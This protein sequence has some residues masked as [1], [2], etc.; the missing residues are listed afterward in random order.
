MTSPQVLANKVAA[1]TGAL[2]GIG[3]AIAIGYLEHGAKV[4]VNYL[5]GQKDEILLEELYGEISNSGFRDHL[6]AI[7]GDI[8]QPETGTKLV[9]AAVDKW[10]RL[11]VFVSNAGIC[12]FAD[13]LT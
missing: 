8:S 11:D 4:A 7:A 6:F 1:I 9:Q 5:G 13:F 2:T 12:Q 10:G 3:R